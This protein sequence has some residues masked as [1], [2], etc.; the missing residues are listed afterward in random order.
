[1]ARYPVGS[2]TKNL[3]WQQTPPG[4]NRLHLVIRS[5]FSGQLEP[6]PRAAF[7]T[8]SGVRDV[9]R[10]LIAVNF[11]L[12]NTIAGGENFVSVDELVRQALEKPHSRH[13]DHLAVF[14]LHLSRLGERTGVAGH[15]NEAAYLNDYARNDLW[16]D[17]GWRRPAVDTANI[18]KVFDASLIAEGSDT[19]HKCATNYHFIL[20]LA[21]YT[22]GITEVINSRFSE[23]S[24]AAFFLA[25]DRYSMDQGSRSPRHAELVRMCHADELHKLM[26]M[27][28][29][30]FGILAEDAAT[31]YIASGGLGRSFTV[32]RQHVEPSETPRSARPRRPRPPAKNEGQVNWT[33]ESSQEAAQVARRLQELSVQLRNPSLGR[34]LKALYRNR[35]CFCRRSIIVGVGPD[36]YYSEAAH[37]R[38]VGKPHNG[39]DRKDNM[40]ILCPEHHVQFDSGILSLRIRRGQLTIASKAPYDRLNGKPVR[41]EP[42]HEINADNTRYHADF[43]RTR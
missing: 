18:E 22:Q 29:A 11:F 36:R 16:V 2:F 15:P 37:I 43:W 40:L 1:M 28:A 8:N 17:D 30:S 9:S 10:Q 41:I 20:S 13:F 31:R 14:A 19:I 7:R 23:W 42:P 12:H 27:P 34:E 32:L 5:G 39:S 35:C 24:T 38:A 3:G 26:G 33:D 6:V 21:G 25:F 4:L